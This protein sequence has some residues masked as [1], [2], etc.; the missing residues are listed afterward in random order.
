MNVRKNV[1]SIERTKN[2]M[3]QQR[4]MKCVKLSQHVLMKM[5][6]GV[7]AQSS[8]FLIWQTICA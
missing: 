3:N 6:V 2:N 4:V 5:L 8:F 7:C 1:M